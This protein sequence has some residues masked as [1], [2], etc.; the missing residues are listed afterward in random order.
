MRNTAGRGGRPQLA[1]VVGIG[2]LA[3]LGLFAVMPTRAQG[4]RSAVPVSF[5]DPAR[6]EPDILRFEAEDRLHAPPEG[7]IVLIGSS[8]IARWNKQA[9]TAL[10]PLTVIP[11]G[12]GGC[13]MHD[14]VHYLDRIA[15]HYRP[16][17]ILIYAGDNDT[18]ADQPIPNDQVLA[19]L[20][21]GIAQVHERLPTT[22]IYLLSVKPSVLRRARWPV[23][24]QLNAGYRDI[25]AQDPLVH[26]VDV[27]TALL[28]E[29]GTARPDLFG[30]DQ[31]HFND[32]GYEIWAA[33][34]KAALMAT[35]GK[36]E[37][38]VVRAP[39]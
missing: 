1:V 30:A 7:A 4:L 35:E 25:A 22:R 16:R 13:V 24:Q 37:R 8:S 3:L 5:P 17:A 20:R 11:R 23:A 38:P 6:F 12:F 10:A 2:G 33:T 39:G 29:D 32:R 26:Y 36:E 21:K 34:I 14:V 9:R 31:L 18:G 15:L 19:D 28:G 27:A